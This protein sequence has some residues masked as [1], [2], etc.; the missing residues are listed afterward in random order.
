MT[1]K[2]GDFWLIKPV[3]C[4]NEIKNGLEE[5]KNQTKWSKME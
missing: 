5:V 4:R 2:S 3:A 1:L